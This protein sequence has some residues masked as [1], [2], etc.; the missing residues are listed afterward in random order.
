MVPPS[1]FANYLVDMPDGLIFEIYHFPHATV[2]SLRRDA[3]KAVARSTW[4]T[5]RPPAQKRP[6]ARAFL[7]MASIA[8]ITWPTTVDRQ[9]NMLLAAHMDPAGVHPPNGRHSSHISVPSIDAPL[10]ASPPVVVGWLRVRVRIDMADHDAALPG[11]SANITPSG[12]SP[13]ET[14]DGAPLSSSRRASSGPSLASS[15]QGAPSQSQ[16][17]YGYGDDEPELDQSYSQPSRAAMPSMSSQVS[18]GAMNNNE[19][20]AA[21]MKRG[22][23]LAREMKQSLSDDDDDMDHYPVSQRHTRA[24]L[25]RSSFVTQGLSIPSVQNELDRLMLGN[26]P[27]A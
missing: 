13:I 19:K 1:N 5:R 11:P 18:S 26:Y 21:I 3:R 27:L 16:P 7:N 4:A 12:V 15:K 20:L 14:K 17:S 10:V 2:E 24:P 8:D 25:P 6:V 23:E 22:T 9:L